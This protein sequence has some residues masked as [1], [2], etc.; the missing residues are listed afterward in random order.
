LADST[1]DEEKN[2]DRA[3]F[4]RGSWKVASTRRKHV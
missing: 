2:R 1:D 4:S 3:K